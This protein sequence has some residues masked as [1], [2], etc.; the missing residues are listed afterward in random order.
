[1]LLTTDPTEV[2]TEIL[3]G[4]VGDT[5]LI[6]S[7]DVS[8]SVSCEES[9]TLITE[10]SLPDVVVDSGLQAS[11]VIFSE[12]TETLIFEFGGNSNPSVPSEHRQEVFIGIPSPLPAYP[13]LVF[14][15]VT[16][17]GQVVMQ[18]Q[19]NMP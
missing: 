2:S 8:V 12:N 14:V 15:P 4:T 5:T 7:D 19:V 18:M 17:Q 11:V 13:A 10:E 16:I 3:E 6:Y 9:E 1:M